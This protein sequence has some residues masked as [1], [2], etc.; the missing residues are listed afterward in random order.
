M[1]IEKG[2]YL[3]I[4]RFLENNS[5]KSLLWSGTKK[6]CAC[7]MCFACYNQLISVP[8]LFRRYLY[9]CCS[10]FLVQIRACR[11]S[12]RYTMLNIIYANLKLIHSCSEGP[13]LHLHVMVL[14]KKNCQIRTILNFQRI[15]VI[16]LTHISQ[17]NV[18]RIMLLLTR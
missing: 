3:S 7:V 4:L 10:Y 1:G 2:F 18:L 14:K 12:D 9:I 17:S 6:N 16:A 13:S 15:V 8:H 5:I 11:Y